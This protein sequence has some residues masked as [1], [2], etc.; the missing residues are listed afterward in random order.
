VTGSRLS[1]AAVLL[2]LTACADGEKLFGNSATGNVDYGTR[3]YTETDADTDTDTDDSGTDA[4][5]HTG[6]THSY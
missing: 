5:P 1:I 2:G 6:S 3:P 4:A